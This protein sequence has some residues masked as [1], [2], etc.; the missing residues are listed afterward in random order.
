VIVAIDGTRV[1]D[2][3]SMYRALWRGE[4]P[5]RDVLVEIRRGSETMRLSVHAVDRM[6][7]L[8]RPKGV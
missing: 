1:A 2:L 8:S 7:T 5:D 4:R 6:S 3:A